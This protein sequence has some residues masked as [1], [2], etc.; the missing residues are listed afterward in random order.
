MQGVWQHL[1]E[2]LTLRLSF[3]M[4]R[5][6]NWAEAIASTNTLRNWLATGGG[7]VSL[8]VFQRARLVPAAA[9]SL[10]L[11]C[12]PPQITAM[13]MA[14]AN[15]PF[16]LLFARAPGLCTTSVVKSLSGTAIP[17]T[18]E[19]LAKMKETIGRDINESEQILI[20]QAFEDSQAELAKLAAAN[21]IVSAFW[22]T[23]PHG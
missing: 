3:Q 5:F 7:D 8:L 6:P 4:S 18:A 20:D 17:T 19:G 22:R 21:P 15:P 9:D 23:R 16:E 11:P 12:C 2:I 10:C 14:V 13:M 1:R